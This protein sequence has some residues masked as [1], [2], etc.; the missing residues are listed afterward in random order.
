MANGS[1]NKRL[2][3]LNR[4]PSPSDSAIYKG[5]PTADA[6]SIRLRKR[7]LPIR[8]KN[9]LIG[10]QNQYGNSIWIYLKSIETIGESLHINRKI[11]KENRKEGFT[12][13]IFSA[14]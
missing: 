12:Y 5:L 11:Y 13:A 3:W 4:I 7:R 9:G 1:K 10:T 2:F 14:D 6:M 8:L